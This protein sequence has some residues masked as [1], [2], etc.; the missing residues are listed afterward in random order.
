MLEFWQMEACT[1][2]WQLENMKGVWICGMARSALITFLFWSLLALGEDENG[3]QSKLAVQPRFQ[4][5]G[6]FEL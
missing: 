6:G 5:F 2:G 3:L 1:K 4:D